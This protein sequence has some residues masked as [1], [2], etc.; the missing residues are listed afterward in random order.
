MIKRILFDLDNTLI[1]WD[2]SQKI[3]LLNT[4]QEC[5]IDFPPDRMDEYFSAM[6]D[7]EKKHKRFDKVEMSKWI[8][9]KLNLDIPDDFIKSWTD[10]LCY[11]VPDKDNELISL[12]EYLSSKYSLCVVSNWF[13]NQQKA[14]L[15]NYGILKYFDKV[16]T[17]DKY[18]KK[19]YKEMFELA[20]NGY[21]NDEVA[22][23]GDDYT[24]DIKSAVDYGMYAF[25]LNS[26]ARYCNKKTKIIRTIYDLRK[27]L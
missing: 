4:F 6:K 24:I 5:D 26:K 9:M 18:D 16:Y 22:M 15:K 20:S 12:L 11:C 8:G 27:Y 7:Y 1:P 23:V 21:S 2:G 19:P 14:R 13:Y 25:Y 3:A 10:K 17:V